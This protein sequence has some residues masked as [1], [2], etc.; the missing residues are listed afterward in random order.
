LPARFWIMSADPG[1]IRASLNAE[2]TISK[3]SARTPECYWIRMIRL[4]AI[5]H[6]FDDSDYD[7]LF[8]SLS[9]PLSAWVVKRSDR[10]SLHF[11]FASID[12]WLYF[13]KICIP[14]SE[15]F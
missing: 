4:D 1:V 3:L 15:C 8:R 9:I 14:M 13:S 10:S 5:K 6:R 12:R 2:W 7:D 11:S